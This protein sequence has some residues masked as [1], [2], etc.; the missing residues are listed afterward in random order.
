VISTETLTQRYLAK[1][2][3]AE[4]V[5]T[6]FVHSRLPADCVLLLSPATFL[7]ELGYEPVLAADQRTG[8]SA[9]EIHIHP[10]AADLSGDHDNGRFGQ[11][12]LGSINSASPRFTTFGITASDGAAAA[13]VLEGVVTWQ[14]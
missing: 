14:T 11:I 2:C 3:S 12:V 6:R 7:L 8:G 1:N 5:K 4:S 9:P 13:S 10:A